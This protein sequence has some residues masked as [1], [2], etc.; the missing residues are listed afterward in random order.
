MENDTCTTVSYEQLTDSWSFSAVEVFQTG[1]VLSAI[2]NIFA[3]VGIYKCRSSFGN[4]GF[5]EQLLTLCLNDALSSMFFFMFALVQSDS[6][7]VGQP[8]RY[9]T[10]LIFIYFQLNSFGNTL[11][12]S[13][14][15]FISI[16]K[17]GELQ[18]TWTRKYTFVFC[19]INCVSIT[20]FLALYLSLRTGVSVMMSNLVF[21]VVVSVCVLVT[22]SL[23]CLTLYYLKRNMKS[24]GG[25]W[26]P[27]TKRTKCD[28][29]MPSQYRTE[30]SSCTL[31]NEN[32]QTGIHKAH[33]KWLAFKQ[34]SWDTNTSVNKPST[35]DISD[36]DKKQV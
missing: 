24:V 35:S 28:P 33:T 29:V 21:V 9:I 30:L 8:I 25:I 16:R 26:T 31:I 23:C 36:P 22:D 1:A 34:Q 10:G 20:L 27:A 11:G 6:N 3:F 2:V 15:R 12:I 18:V 19:F 14:Q 4:N 32:P 17:A 5:W 7:T 13:L